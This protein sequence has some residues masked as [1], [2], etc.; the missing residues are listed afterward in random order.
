MVATVVVTIGWFMYL[1]YVDES[2]DPGLI[3]SPTRYFGLS[4]IV[5]HE[6]QWHVFHEALIN[7]RYTMNQVYNLPIRREIHASE[8]LN[9]SLLNIPKY[10][11]LA[12]LRNF[13]DELAKL[14]YL[15]ITSVIVDKQ[16][17][18]NQYETF[19]QAWS[20][21]FQR[22]ENTLKYGNFPGAYRTDYGL[23]ITDNTDGKKLTKLVR[24]MN[25]YN[26]IPNMHQFG[27]GYRNIPIVKIIED[28]YTKD[29][30]HSYMIQAAD[31]A[32]YFLYQKYKP[33]AYIKKQGARHYYNRMNPI[34]NTR[35]S[36]TNGFG[37]VQ[38]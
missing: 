20:T 25:K 33:S 10:Q 2:G 31:V 23:A 36:N 37:I 6:S 8:Y 11:R 29:S 38:I 32:A 34:L 27:D 1:M 12:I 18:P 14:N 16:G 4:G 15:S 24:K 26:P 3:N 17:K 19:N 9:K 7:F 28:P 30:Q 5:I 13:L 35:A 22:F 21:L